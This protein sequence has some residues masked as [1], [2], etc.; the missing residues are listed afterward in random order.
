MVFSERQIH[1]CSSLCIMQLTSISLISDLG[2][3]LVRG[4]TAATTKDGVN[5]FTS[6]L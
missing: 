2:N 5:S 3:R 6:V 4:I 1:M